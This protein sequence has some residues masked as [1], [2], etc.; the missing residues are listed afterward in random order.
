MLAFIV[1]IAGGTW[2]VRSY[3][4]SSP[5][6]PTIAAPAAPT[7]QPDNGLTALQK[8]LE[9]VQ[10]DKEATEAKLKELEKS[11]SEAVAKQADE[12]KASDNKGEFNTPF[13]DLK[14]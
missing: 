3:L 10:K 13:A 12:A 11:Q 8:Q 1:I 14:N 4:S 7:A 6:Q 9:Q 2:A 5:T